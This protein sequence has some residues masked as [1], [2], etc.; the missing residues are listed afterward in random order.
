M[1]NIQGKFGTL[2]THM[3]LFWRPPQ[4]TGEITVGFPLKLAENGYPPLKEEKDR[5]I[6]TKRHKI[7]QIL[8]PQAHVCYCL[9]R[10]LRLGEAHG[11]LLAQKKDR[12]AESIPYIYIYIHTIRLKMI[13]PPPPKCNGVNSVSLQNPQGFLQNESQSHI[14][15]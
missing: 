12:C 11:G 10:L 15:I 8:K 1:R 13:E 4:A 5:P 6:G 3:G 2:G 14:Q 9:L 7:L